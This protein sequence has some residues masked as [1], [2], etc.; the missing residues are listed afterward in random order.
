MSARKPTPREFAAVLYALAVAR[1]TLSSARLGDMDAE[2]LKD[3]IERILKGTSAA[4]IAKA[5]GLKENDIT[6]DWNELL[7][8][9]EMHLIGGGDDA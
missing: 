2:E 8:E 5:L 6:L 9:A 3:E 7:T 4:T 1:G